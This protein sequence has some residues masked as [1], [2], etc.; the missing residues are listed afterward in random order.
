MIIRSKGAAGVIKTASNTPLVNVAAVITLAATAGKRYR[1]NK[2]I[3]SYNA[4]PTGGK[5]TITVNA[6][7][8]LVLDLPSVG[9]YD[10]DLLIEAAEKQAV[11]IT[12]AA[13]GAAVT[14]KLYTEYEE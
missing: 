10:F 2:V 5:L 8:I 1:L 3:A 13:A 12:L 9:V 6:V 7:D 4:A 14:G 11:V